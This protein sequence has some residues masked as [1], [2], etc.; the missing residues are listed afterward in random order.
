MFTAIDDYMKLSKETRQRHLN[1]KDSCI[2]IG[3][4][5]QQCRALLAHTLK[6]TVP[7]GMK[8]HLCH[9]CHNSKCSNSNHLYWGTS[10][11]NT[12]DTMDYFGFNP[13]AQAT[14]G[15]KWSQSREAAQKISRA[16]K[17]RPSNNKLGVNQ[18]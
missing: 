17:G 1:L 15:K 6:T 11:E 14:K 13:G 8:V 10:S 16:L 4:N 7:K 18:F 9:A 5:S 2:E 12:R 3:T